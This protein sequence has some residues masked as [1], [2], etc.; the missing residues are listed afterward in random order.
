MAANN[1]DHINQVLRGL[2]GVRIDE[3]IH[4]SRGGKAYPKEVRELVLQMILDG[5]IN[6]VKTPQIRHLMEQ[7]KF[8]SLVTC[9][10][11]LRQYLTLGHI[12]PKRKTANRVATREITGEALVQLAFYR[13]IR[14]HARLYEVKAYLSNRFPNIPPYSDSQIC[15]AELRLGLSRKVSS[16]TSQDAYKPINLAKRKFYW[17]R[18]YPLGIAGEQTSRIIDIDE[19]RFKLESADR[20]Y[21]KVAR[22]FRSNLRGKYKKGAPGSNLI[23][24]ISGDGNNSYEFHQQFTEGG[25]DL[26]RFFCFMRDLIADLQVNFPGVSFCFTM[27]NL[28][29]HK[30]PAV[31]DEIESHGHRV[32]YRA[33]YWSCDD[34]IEYVFNTIHTFLEMDDSVHMENVDDLVNRIDLIIAGLPSFRRYFLHVGFQDN[35]IKGLYYYGASLE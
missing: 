3:S 30:H 29:I 19:A 32:V 9:R 15:R 23:M 22:E 27:D 31:L 11:W 34:A 2:R 7:K 4:A 16:R 17:E 26:W 14:P 20:K 12:R 24:A 28:N 21:G 10:R 25:T 1:Q 35:L 8:P 6:A 33:P 13:A 5:G 18:T